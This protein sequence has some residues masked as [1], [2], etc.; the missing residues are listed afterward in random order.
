MTA[1]VEGDVAIRPLAAGDWLT[2]ERIYAE[3]IATGN[4][5][6]ETSTP[7]WEEWDAAHLQEPRL[8][9]EAGGRVV[10]WAALSPVSR[11]AAYAG[12]AE[13]SIY[14][15]GEAQR[16]GIGARLLRALVE[17]SET[18]GIWTL[19]ATI[20]TENDVSIRLHER[21]GFRIVGTRE[22]IGRLD[23]IWRDTVL[24]ERRS[25]AVQ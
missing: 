22:R 2:V 15:A 13:V 11:R 3:G 23:G 7:S 25:P 21:A 8:V 18:C 19:Q 20:F 6:F 17:G 9:V 5:T 1:T 12:V 24:M 16:R 4:A 10:A 14:V